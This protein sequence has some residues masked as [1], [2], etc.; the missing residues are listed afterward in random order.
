MAMATH[1]S[2]PPSSKSFLTFHQSTL[3]P[4][5][6]HVPV[7]RIG[8]N[9][10]SAH[11]SFRIENVTSSMKNRRI[12]ILFAQPSDGDIVEDKSEGIDTSGNQGPPILTILAGFLV[13]LLVFW[14]LG[15]I[16]TWLIS[17]IVTISPSK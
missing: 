8:G 13:L 4:E 6:S 5:I 1:L 12:P 15:S 14:V 2:A 11:L 16:A 7:R 10:S 3:K 17:L 9:I